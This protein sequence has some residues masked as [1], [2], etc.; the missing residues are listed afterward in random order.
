MAN[1]T[2][3][4]MIM[5]AGLKNYQVAAKLG[6][7]EG[8]FSRL[9]REELSQEWLEKIEAAVNELKGTRADASL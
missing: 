6:I 4:T 5:A 1:I 3:R 9:L 8:Y 2:I 7:S